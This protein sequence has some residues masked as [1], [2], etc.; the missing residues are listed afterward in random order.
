M[1]E[2]CAGL[3]SGLLALASAGL[4]SRLS[5][6]AYEVLHSAVLLRDAL[7][8]AA[9]CVP[10]SLRHGFATVADMLAQLPGDIPVGGWVGLPSCCC[11]SAV[12][13]PLAGN[14]VL[15]LRG[16]GCLIS[17]CASVR[18]LLR[19]GQRTRFP[20]A[21]CLLATQLCLGLR[22]RSRACSTATS[23][24]GEQWSA[25]PGVPLSI[26]IAPG[27]AATS[28]RRRRGWTTLV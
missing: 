5:I 9:R 10:A 14:T 12:A 3:G 18:C 26:E 19:H 23:G 16:R 7:I 20:C 6:G 4:C 1:Y 2:L 11:C 13:V 24:V 28:S 17:V 25:D 21:P 15:C 8:I 27:D 22:G